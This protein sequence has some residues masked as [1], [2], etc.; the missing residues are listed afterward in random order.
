M[1]HT[2][3]LSNG[4]EPLKIISWKKA[5]VLVYL[6][7]A[8]VVEAY[9]EQVHAP[10]LTLPLPAVVRL[11]RYVRYLP[12]RVKFSRQNLF[13]RDNYTCQYCH[14]PHPPSQ[15]TYDHVVP[16]SYGGKTTWTNI[17]T[18]CK[19]CNH[20]KG[21]K[22]LHLVSFKLLRDPVEPKW[23]PLFSPLI[24]SDATPIVWRD[25]LGAALPAAL[26]R[27]GDAAD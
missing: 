22:P 13:F 4:F 5:I 19:R 27:T 7:K 24:H 1:R 21:D 6:E 26:G 8:E 11:H 25:Y 9:G 20:R 14:K 2:L 10:T 16:R 18:A 17:V 3:L 23:M 12:Q 15:L